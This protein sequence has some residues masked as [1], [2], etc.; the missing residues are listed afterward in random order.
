[1][2]IPVLPASFRS[3]VTVRRALLTIADFANQLEKIQPQ[4]LGARPPLSTAL[5]IGTMD[6]PSRALTHAPSSQTWRPLPKARRGGPRGVRLGYP[7]SRNFRRVSGRTSL[8]SWGAARRPAR[9]ARRVGARDPS[10]GAPHPPPPRTKWTRRVPHPVLIGHAASLGRF[11]PSPNPALAS[12]V[13]GDLVAVS[14]TTLPDTRTRPLPGRPTGG[15]GALG[16]NGTPSRAPGRAGSRA[17]TSVR[18]RVSVRP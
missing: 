6:P 11:P 4:A 9:A 8:H 2:V 14:P 7:R 16:S 1:M 17:S 10:R 18:S 15:P 5:Q 13:A 12:A 3:V